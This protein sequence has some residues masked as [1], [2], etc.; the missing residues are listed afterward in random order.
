MEPRY[1][2]LRNFLQCYCPSIVS[3]TLPYPQYLT[4]RG[5]S[6][7]GKIRKGIDELCIFIKNPLC[8][9]LLKHNFRDEDMIW[10]VSHPPRQG[11]AVFLIVMV[12]KFLKRPNCIGR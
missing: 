10:V 5:L 8:L 1:H 12:D 4:E 11:A 6:E 9:S 2:H 7:G 3:Q